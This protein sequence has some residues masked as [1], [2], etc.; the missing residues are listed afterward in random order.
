VQPPLFPSLSIQAFV[1]FFSY[2]HQMSPKKSFHLLLGC[3]SIYHS[4]SFLLDCNFNIISWLIE[5]YAFCVEF[6]WKSICLLTFNKPNLIVGFQAI[7]LIYC[8]LLF[9]DQ[10]NFMLRFIQK[11]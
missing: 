5:I 7:K 8:A 2:I 9:V 3:C 6:F 10:S 11:K 4:S 1:L